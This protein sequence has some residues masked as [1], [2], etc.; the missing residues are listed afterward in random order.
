MP[1]RVGSSEG[2]GLSLGFAAKRSRYACRPQ[3]LAWHAAQLVEQPQP[4]PLPPPRTR[5]KGRRS[6]A[7]GEPH[8]PCLADGPTRGAT[9]AVAS[10]ADQHVVGRLDSLPAPTGSTNR[11]PAILSLQETRS[12]GTV[13][14]EETAPR[15][16]RLGATEI[17]AI[18]SMWFVPLAAHSPRRPRLM[19]LGHNGCS[20]TPRSEVPQS[21]A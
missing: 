3:L 18:S 15:S 6:S 10:P 16:V 19:S 2:L 7:G 4:R 5:W 13:L 12:G 20:R 21:E 1:E 9:P 11:L 8:S 17:R 14:S